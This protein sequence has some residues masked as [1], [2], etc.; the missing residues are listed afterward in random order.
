M[1]RA[2]LC[3]FLFLKVE[4]KVEHFCFF[5][6]S[7]G[8]GSH[9]C[10]ISAGC[11]P[12]NPELNGVAPGAQ[13]L[14]IRISD[15]RVGTL[16]SQLSLDRLAKV[17][18][19]NK[20]DILSMSFIEADFAGA[21]RYALA[22]Q[23]LIMDHNILVCISGGNA[24]PVYHVGAH[25]APNKAPSFEVGA[26][27]TPEI[28]ETGYGMHKPSPV[29][30]FNF[31]NR[32]PSIQSG[33]GVNICAPGSAFA[34]A[35]AYELK[36]LHHA[37]GTSMACPNL[38]GSLALLVSGLKALKV[39]LFP[40]V[41]FSMFDSFSFFRWSTRLGTFGLQ[42]LELQNRSKKLLGLIQD[43]ALFKF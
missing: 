42:F 1:K 12:S 39:I 41:V 43:S 13:L 25:P 31:S 26:I 34:S 21:G 37:H 10:G 30:L 17:L 29:K 14:N 15:F 6:N 4:R 23:K 5:N 38:A 9:C 28:S 22:L 19:D 20:V 33:M 11:H 2:T 24:G 32:A 18:I 8:H 36:S 35:P 40:F 16:E 7:Q 3:P 27:M